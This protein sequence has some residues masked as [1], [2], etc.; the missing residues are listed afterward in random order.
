MWALYAA[1]SALFA[2][3]SSI[4]AK[5]GVEN[6]NSHLATALR[7]VVVVV[8][9]WALVFVTGNHRRAALGYRTLL[10]L[11]LSGIATG[12]SWLC[13]YQALQIGET[14]KVM[15]VDKFSLVIGIILASALLKEPLTPKTLVGAGLITI[16]TV[17]L[18]R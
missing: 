5:I 3:L 6:V 2:A 10:F 16:G 8:M 18:I 14:S 17:V 4:L 11:G 15:A 12:L 1:L 9:A 7:T 13:Y